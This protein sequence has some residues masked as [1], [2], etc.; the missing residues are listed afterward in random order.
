MRRFIACL[1][2]VSAVGL[3]YGQS[4]GF[5]VGVDVGVF[6]P[7]D[8]GVRDTF[9]K[10]W[11]RIGLTPL[12]FQKPDNWKTSFDFVYL[13]QRKSGN[14]VTLIPVTFGATRSFGNNQMMRPYVAFRVGPYWGDV[15]SPDLGVNSSRVGIDVN[16]SLGVT[17]NNMFYVEARY[18]YM[19]DFKGL[20][21]NG[22]FISAGIRLFELR[23]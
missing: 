2:A 13:H 18:D 10:S 19:S 23:L 22:F 12:S 14:S 21:F 7:V 3:A 1:F 8:K 4:G 5:P 16:G 11:T 6:F 15:D 9:G 17:F 20:N